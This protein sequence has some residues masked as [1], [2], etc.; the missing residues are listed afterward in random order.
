MTRPASIQV[1]NSP[2][3]AVPSVKRW[4]FLLCLLCVAPLILRSLP[5]HLQRGIAP[6]LLEWTAVC[7]AAFVAMFTFVHAHLKREGSA[8][9]IGIALVC[10]AAM[11]AVHTLAINGMVNAVVEHDKL[12]PFMGV[13]CRL[14]N[15]CILTAGLAVT[16]ARKNRSS[17]Q[18]LLLVTCMGG[19]FIAAAYLTTALCMRA[20]RLPQ[21]MF[22][23]LL[24]KRPYD[25]LPV[26]PFVLVGV[27][28]GPLYIR[29]TRAAFGASLSLAMIPGIAAQFYMVFGSAHIHDVCFVIA[30]GL[31]VVS[32]CVMLAGS[33]VEYAQSYREQDRLVKES[34]AAKV[35]LD[36][37]AQ[38]QADAIVHSA[39]LLSQLE[40][41]NEALEMARVEATMA[42]K[43][44]ADFLANMSHEIRT[45]M[46]AI[47]GFTDTL[48]EEGDIRL[49][50]KQRI[51]AID[52]IHRN[53]HYLLA[54]INDILDAAKLDA[55]KM[56]VE[57]VL[58][59]PHLIVKDVLELMKVRSDAKNL[60]L[61]A[62]FIDAVPESIRSDPTRMKQI[63]VNLVGNAIKFTDEGGVRLIVRCVHDGSEPFMQFDIL[64]TGHG[65]TEEQAS[66][67]FEPFAQADE[68]TT[69]THGGTGLGLTISKALASLL[70]GDVAIVDTK[71]GC[72]TR[73]RATIGTGSLEGVRMIEGASD[74]LHESSSD[75]PEAKRLARREEEPPLNCRILLAEDGPDNQRLISFLLGKA[76]A[77]VTIADNGQVAFDRAMAALEAGTPYDV[78]LMDMQMPVLDGYKST[79]ALREAN[80]DGYII[81][82]TAHAMTSDRAK[83]INSGCDDF[84]TKPVDRQQL[85]EMIR[86]RV[87]RESSLTPSRP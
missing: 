26:V 37:Q 64:D 57:R 81:A 71:P 72:G 1:Q 33:F 62:E 60:T 24:A 23:D 8:A 66:R 86:Q 42:A 85:I 31:K 83:C 25:L 50:P 65:M 55:R 28:L 59:S 2:L 12:A 16:L 30:Q 44:K 51:E 41:A 61:H 35:G 36:R 10:A 27:F 18:S 63:L 56:T 14:F 15:G 75:R 87:C 78:I 5:T 45:P 19:A 3:G 11:D 20:S 77:D 40:A 68:T 21:M 47:L 58:C 67:L 70:G 6:I 22:P 73:F 4:A 32:Y 43:A 46:T 13:V 52:T 69:R 82:L 54:I 76:G 53:G 39:E 80:Y 79:M 17:Q 9:I 34:L 49:A 7:A 48:R 74:A 84:A 38:A 29:R